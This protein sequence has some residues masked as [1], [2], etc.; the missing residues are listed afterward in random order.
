MSKTDE[1]KKLAEK[2]TGE[3]PSGR[4]A[5]NVVE[6]IA[7]KIS[8]DTKDATTIS[9]SIAYLTDVYESGGTLQEKEVTITE[10]GTTTVT[11]DEE[12]DGLSSVEVT[13]NIPSGN[14]VLD[15]EKYSYI[16]SNGSPSRF[17]T[18]LKSIEL[19]CA[20]I[21]TFEN[22]FK[23]CIAATSIN[24]TNVNTSNNI[25]FHWAFY[26]CSSL[27]NLDI[28]NIS[29]IRF[30]SIVSC[31]QG[32]ES[33]VNLPVLDLQYAT[34]TN[35]LSNAFKDCTSLSNDSLHNIL[36]SLLTKTSYTSYNKNL[37]HIGLS[38]EQATIC[39]T[40]DEWTTL[41]ASGWTT[42]Y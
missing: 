10:N 20:N 26:G 34:G 31:F 36:K 9:E 21:T 39:T 42:G 16:A 22:C 12:Y 5:S 37:S 8:G 4:R 25:N 14:G 3:T 30:Y 35:S 11:P 18:L 23:D 41:S 27:T 19:N 1:L 32:C 29:S 6:F 40:F 38:S 33:L 7:D 24:L 17:P 2:I 28:D 13:T 15:A